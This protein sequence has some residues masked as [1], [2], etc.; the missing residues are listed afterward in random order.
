MYGFSKLVY[1]NVITN[2]AKCREGRAIAESSLS[3]THSIYSV[4]KSC[5]LFPL[6]P[7][8][9]SS[10]LSIPCLVLQWAPV[11][12]W[13][14]LLLPVVCS[15]ALGRMIPLEHSQIMPCFACLRRSLSPESGLQ[16]PGRF[17]GTPSR[18]FV[19]CCSPSSLP[20]S[21]LAGRLA[22]AE[23]SRP[24]ASSGPLLVGLSAWS[25]LPTSILT[26]PSL[27]GLL[28]QICSHCCITKT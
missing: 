7:F 4:S 18:F 23:H 21:S 13:L 25:A 24:A 6:D 9:T 26:A 15:N 17:A 20:Y 19:S 27:P 22:V 3:F 14:L 11:F 8:I 28:C 2:P 16:G 12:S 5:R 10:L 1:T